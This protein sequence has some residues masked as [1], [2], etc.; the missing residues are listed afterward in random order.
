MGADMPAPDLAPPVSEQLLAT[1]AEGLEA[2]PQP[3]KRVIVMGAGIAGLV[4]AYE[5]KRQ[6]HQPLVLEAQR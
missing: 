5:L 4:A 1:P 3:G 6:G 2:R